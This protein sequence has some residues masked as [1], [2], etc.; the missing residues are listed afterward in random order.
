MI[1]L[2]RQL[3]EVQVQMGAVERV[4]EY[5][6]L[7]PEERARPAAAAPGTAEATPLLQVQQGEDG[8][9]LLVPP[10]D[11]PHAG[12]IE[13]RHLS[14]RYRQHLPPALNDVSFQIHAGERVGVVG[15]T[16]GG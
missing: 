16:V 13:A 14:L 11:W 7:E 1:W 4:L 12:A 8:E 15:R 3:A 9:P 6:R 10:P 5:A 2:V